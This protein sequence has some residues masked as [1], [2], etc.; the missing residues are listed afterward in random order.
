MTTK[1]DHAKDTIE[2]LIVDDSVT[3]AEQL[4]HLLEQQHYRIFV[5]S[6]GKQALAILDEHKPALV[7]SDIIMPEMNGFELCK[8]IKSDERS[9][10]IPVILLTSLSN[11]E[12]VLEGLTCGADNF[13]TKPYSEEYLLLHI[14]QILANRKLRKNERVRV[15]VEIMFAGKRRFITADQQQMLSLLISTYEAA[16]RKNIELVQTQNE[17]R[18][19]NARLEEM[20]EERTEALTTEIGE[21]KRAKLLLE[22]QYTLLTALIDSPGDIIIFSLDKNYCY[23]T[24]NKKHREEMKRLWNADIRIGTNLLECIQI[25]ELRTLAKQSIDRT[26]LGEVFSEIQH[27]PNMNICYEFSWNPI[28][29]NE[30]IVGVTV[31]IRDITERMRAE[32]EN[33][34]Q[35]EELLRWQE[36]MLDREDRNRK[37]KREVNELLNRLGEPIRYPSQDIDAPEKKANEAL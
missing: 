17:L 6:S 4:K 20:V 2:I 8:Q 11:A 15:G 36:V 9:Q 29:Q 32:E 24:F 34:R 1:N 31:F 22:S 33:R 18:S 26:L 10:H 7:I 35:L 14:E 3:Q 28:Y 12:D 13:I 16:F 5:A 37:L 19:L 21:H 27:Q 23:T 25:P 30:E